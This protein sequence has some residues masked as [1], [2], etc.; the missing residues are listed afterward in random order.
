MP[1][2]N[3]P[4]FS[5][6][7]LH[8][9][10]IRRRGLL[11]HPE[12]LE[13]LDSLG[14]SGEHLATQPE[15]WLEAV[16]KIASASQ[17]RVIS[18]VG[19]LALVMTL[20]QAAASKFPGQLATPAFVSLIANLQPLDHLVLCADRQNEIAHFSRTAV[21]I[22]SHILPAA[23]TVFFEMPRKD[24]IEMFAAFMDRVIGA[25]CEMEIGIHDDDRDQYLVDA[26]GDT[27]YAGRFDVLKSTSNGPDMAL[28]SLG[29][30]VGRFYDSREELLSGDAL[31]HSMT[32]QEYANSQY[33]MLIEVGVHE[34]IHACDDSLVDRS[35]F[36]RDRAFSSDD[37]YHRALATLL[38]ASV[39]TFVNRS[40]AIARI[41]P[42]FRS[43]WLPLHERASWF[44]SWMTRESL[45]KSAFFDAGVRGAA[46]LSDPMEREA[47]A[48]LVGIRAGT[49]VAV[50]E[51]QSDL[52]RVEDHHAPL[53]A[54]HFRV[55]TEPFRFLSAQEESA[56]N[57]RA[58]ELSGPD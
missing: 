49:A 57:H 52:L 5:H 24:R 39:S 29:G 54:G 41:D 31:A 16:K 9:D 25:A 23:G 44:A 37:E 1:R 47:V 15:S 17:T 55:V 20:V 19:S 8:L 43:I 46:R 18:P 45:A 42:I 32:L 35:S 11:E 33:G 36:A 10:T 13:F 22:A 58:D 53:P 38:G 27:A 56:L 34:I 4:D 7:V 51:N 28:F 14:M 3:D 40:Q 2:L 48:R 50:C 30:P 12:P 21:E 26:T 6:V